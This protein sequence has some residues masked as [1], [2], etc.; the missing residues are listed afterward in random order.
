MNP[1][2]A[3]LLEELPKHN[4]KV[5]PSAVKAGY[6][7]KYADKAP[8][9]I[10]KTAMKA[11]AQALMETANNSANV[12]STEIKRELSSAIGITREELQIAL[13]KIALNERD[14][15]SALKV[16]SALA[17]VDLDLNLQPDEAPK[18]VV[19]VLNIGVRQANE[20]VRNGSVEPPIDITPTV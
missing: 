4:Y 11:Q 19:P 3:K 6:S 1:R 15:S 2:H 14:F 20:I 13:R 18:V 8:K 16:L 12:P 7:K 5:Y 17:K 9:A 10:L